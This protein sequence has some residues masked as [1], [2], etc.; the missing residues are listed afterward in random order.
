MIGPYLTVRFRRIVSISAKDLRS[1]GRPPRKGRVLG[2]GGRR[3]SLGKM[4]SLRNFSK[5]DIQ[6]VTT[7]VKTHVSIFVTEYG[8]WRR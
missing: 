7:M 2:P 3:F 1:H 8:E 5:A 6:R 4:R